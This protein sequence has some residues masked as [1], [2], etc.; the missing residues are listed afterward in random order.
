M[1]E[2]RHKGV[3]EEETPT[4]ARSEEAPN[5][6]ESMPQEEEEVELWPRAMALDVKLACHNFKV[7]HT[8]TR[9]VNIRARATPSKDL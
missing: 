3:E 9:N 6:E 2:D 8:L 7:P 5:T 4:K 1:R